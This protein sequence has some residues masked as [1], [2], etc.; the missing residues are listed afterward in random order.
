MGE[1]P[2][3]E[4]CEQG[5][6]GD[7][8]GGMEPS[9]TSGINSLSY[10]SGNNLLLGPQILL[11]GGSKGTSVELGDSG[12]WTPT[13]D[14]ATATL[15]WWNSGIH[16]Q[17]CGMAPHPLVSARAL[18]SLPHHHSTAKRSSRPLSHVKVAL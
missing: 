10:P 4:Q 15:E 1:K 9:P 7:L 6:C 2:I 17:P 3:P 14:A 12:L 18:W 5:P 8:Q 16:C 11:A 13:V